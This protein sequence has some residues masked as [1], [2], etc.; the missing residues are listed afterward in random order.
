MPLLTTK[1]RKVSKWGR[2]RGGIDLATQGG[3]TKWHT[4]PAASALTSGT[5]VF[6]VSGTR[7]TGSL[8]VGINTLVTGIGFLVGS[9]GGTNTA[10]VELHDIDG[11]LLANSTTAGVTVGS[12]AGYQELSF[13]TP[14]Q[15]VGPQFYYLSV[16]YNGGTAKLRALPA[17]QGQ[18]VMTFSKSNTGTFGTVG[19]LTSAQLPTTFVADVAPV[20]YIF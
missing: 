13:V 10:I 4:W 16:T 12:A 9:V 7:F 11:R 2:L 15:I 5:D 17:S 3:P 8:F 19:D 1:F 14:V 18:S 6:G 20:G